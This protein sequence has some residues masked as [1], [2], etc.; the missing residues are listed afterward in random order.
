MTA[1]KVK[2]RKP[3]KPP[4]GPPELPPHLFE[5]RDE[6]LLA[7]LEVESDGVVV[8]CIAERRND[9]PAHFRCAGASELLPCSSRPLVCC[10]R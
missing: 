7:A 4:A 3:T 1:T 2:G 8:R 6:E 10:Q 5:L 9:G